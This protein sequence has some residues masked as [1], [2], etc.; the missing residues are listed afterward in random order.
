MPPVELPAPRFAAEPPHADLPVGRWAHRLREAFLKACGELDTGEDEL[1]ELREPVFYP[2]RSWHGYSYVPVTVATNGGFE[3]FGHVRFLAAT[4]VGDV[5]ELDASVDY[6]DET[7]ERN[8]DWT[9]DLA[10]DVIG[11]WRGEGADRAA[12]TLVWGRALVE[13]AAVATAELGEEVVDQCALSD[14][15]FTLIAPDDYRGELLSIA[16]W[17]AH[18]VELARESLYGDDDEEGEEEE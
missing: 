17:G 14:A 7:A 10:D 12:M 6:T 11:A 15:R 16:L 3:I 1:G 8:L 5:D 9:I 2:D 13:G 18:G 4:D